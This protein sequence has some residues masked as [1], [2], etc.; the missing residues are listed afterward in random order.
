MELRVQELKAS[1]DSLTVSV[2]NLANSVSILQSDI[3]DEER[4]NM[5]LHKRVKIL[6]AY[7]IKMA[8]Y[9]SVAVLVGGIALRIV[10]IGIDF[11]LIH[12]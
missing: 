1:I 8:G 4:G 2:N 6:E 3:E 10:N 7:N 9:V 11:L 5:A 12:K